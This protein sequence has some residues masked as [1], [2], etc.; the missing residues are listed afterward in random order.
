MSK[1]ANCSGLGSSSQRGMA[2]NIPEGI[3]DWAGDVEGT[4]RELTS[5]GPLLYV[6]SEVV[7]RHYL[8]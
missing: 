2:G 7:C 3:F 1:T 6:G 5:A 8:I 4:R